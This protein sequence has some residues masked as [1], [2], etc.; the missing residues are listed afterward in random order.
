[1]Q[2]IYKVGV[3]GCAHIATRSMIPA[4]FDSRRFELVGIASRTFEKALLVAERYNCQVYSTYDDLLND[5]AIDLIYIPLPTGLHY[6]WVLKALNKKKHVLCEK[7]LASNYPEV[8]EITELARKNG[9][10]LIE[11]FQFRF[12]SQHAWVK[13]FLIENGIGDIRC[14]RSSFG[15]P[16]FPDKDNIRYSKLLGGGALLDAGAYTLKALQV[17]LPDYN[18]K[19]KAASLYQKNTEVDLW[20]GIY[21]DCSEGIIAE[22]SFGFDNYYQCNYEIW[23]TKGKIIS[24]RAFTAPADLKPIIIIEKNNKQELIELDADNHFSNMLDH[25]ANR[26]DS[27]QY[28]DEYQE[29]LTQA[30]YINDVRNSINANK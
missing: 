4:F 18:F 27:D 17:I 7:S 30:S 11:N 13:N 25:I 5:G 8:K 12:H 3:L 1:M 6:G 29:N 10:L 14:F 16:P 26:L 2:R 23:G 22:L 15:F 24:T 20:G 9:L 21:L 28:K 19:V